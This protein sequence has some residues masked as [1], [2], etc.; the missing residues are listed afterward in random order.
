ML[1]TRQAN[2]FL[3]AIYNSIS[4][5]IDRTFIPLNAIDVGQ[6]HAAL[7]CRTCLFFG[8]L[9]ICGDVA[10]SRR[11]HVEFAKRDLAFD[12]HQHHSGARRLHSGRI[13]GLAMISVPRRPLWRGAGIGYLHAR[14]RRE[15]L[16]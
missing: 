8:F 10:A 9:R 4:L 7:F 3:C 1:V 16:V 13:F 2:D 5:L 14:L 6:F 11:L 12:V 15:T